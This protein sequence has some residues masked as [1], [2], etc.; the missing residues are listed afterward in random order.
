MSA[1]IAMLC[2]DQRLVIAASLV[3]S[4]RSSARLLSDSGDRVTCNNPAEATKLT[5]TA[6]SMAG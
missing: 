1:C 3:P 2:C 4:A 6:Q 5:S